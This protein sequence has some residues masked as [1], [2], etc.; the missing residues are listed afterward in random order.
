M[1]AMSQK[2]ILVIDDDDFVRGMICNALRKEN[3]LVEEAHNGNEGV[4]K[5]RSFKPA[6]VITDMLMPDKEGIETILE[7][8]AVNKDIKIIAMS[9]G[10]SSKNM[11]FLEMAKKVGAEQVLS[12]PFKPSA[13][14]EAIRSVLT[15]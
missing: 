8:K 11:T 10:G 7:I 12:K 4:Q 1:D 5:S 15:S 6:V 14:I 2:K 3:F 9:G 13:M